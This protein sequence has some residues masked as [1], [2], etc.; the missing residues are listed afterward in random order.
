MG[1]ETPNRAGG[2]RSGAAG[3][4]RYNPPIVGGEKSH[5]RTG[6]ITGDIAQVDAVGDVGGRIVGP[7]IQVVAGG[8]AAGGGR[9]PTQRGRGLYHDLIIHRADHHRG[10]R[11]DGRHE[12]VALV[13]SDIRSGVVA[14]VIVKIEVPAGDRQG[15]SFDQS[16]SGGAYVQVVGLQHTHEG[17]TFRQGSQFAGGHGV[18]VISQGLVGTAVVIADQV[19]GAWSSGIVDIAVGAGGKIGKAGI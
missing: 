16:G 3:V 12:E 10:I 8:R 2:E 4:V 14:V 15:V 1:L 17:H 7:E 5:V 6:I 18:F 11:S 13:G 19:F 9:S